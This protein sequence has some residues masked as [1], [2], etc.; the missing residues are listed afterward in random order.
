MRAS[1]DF[2]ARLAATLVACVALPMTLVSQSV[3]DAPPLRISTHLVQFGVIVR[4]ANGP[5]GNLTK[6]DFQ[7]I[8]C[9]A[10]QAIRVFSVESSE[11]AVEPAKP[12]AQDTY[13]DQL[14]SGA[15]RPR[16]V[17]IILLDN[18]NT[19][20][21]STP[22]PHESTPRWLEDHA[23]AVAQQHLIEFLTQMDPRDRIAIY[24]LTDKLHVLCD[25]TCSRDQLLAVV[26]RYDATGKT[27]R[28]I[29]EPGTY[30][31]DTDPEKNQHGFEAGQN[32]GA[33]EL[34]AMKNE[35][36]AAATMA[37]LTS[38]AAHVADIPGRKNLLWLTGNLVISGQ[39]AASILVRGN[40]AAYPVDARGLLPRQP[41]MDMSEV[42]DAD[43]NAMG[44]GGAGS[45]SPMSAQPVGIDAMEAMAEDTGGHAFVNTNDLTGAIRKAV[46][47][48]AVTYT[49]GFYLDPRS[50]DGKFHKL[51]VEVKRPG[52]NVTYPKGYFAFKDEPATEDENRKSFL[53]A[54][55]SPLNSSAIPLEVKVES[56]GQAATRS[57]QIAGTVGLK[58]ALL[59]KDGEM[60]R[61]KL[62]IYTIEQDAQGNVLQQ[63][64]SRL[65]LNLTEQQYQAYTQSGI[66]FRKSVE[67]KQGSTV[68]RVLVQY[69]GTPAVGSVIIP[70]AKSN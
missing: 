10:T 44:G 54:I 45:S 9:G 57:L 26:R 3:T 28:D 17:T 2:L 50:V 53:T 55:R 51:R 38:I 52:L 67:P 7:V 62:D 65:N 58:D 14:Q 68:L 70:L 43:K 31:F 8:D 24:G 39:A 33:A 66:F 49:L 63:T 32:E 42:V 21:S 19:L 27:A 4:D 47:D 41:L 20:S 59:P 16:S 1:V 35:D 61:G 11:A 69:S 13:S 34:S 36:R 64:N 30:S 22:L 60:R 23:L 6:D 40:I 56:A 15:S 46:E 12:L 29:A 25:F 48:S 5:V 37:A 18:L